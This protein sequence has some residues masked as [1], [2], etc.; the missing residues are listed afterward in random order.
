MSDVN[1]CTADLQSLIRMDPEFRG[2]VQR[3]LAAD[4]NIFVKQLYEDLDD[5]IQN[6]E[7]DKHF[8]QDAKWGE[9]EL[10]A[11]IKNFL[12]GRFYDVEHDT[13]HG[14]HVDLLVKH[15]FGKFEW[16]GETKLWRGPKSIHNGWIQLTERYGTGTSRDDHGGILIY[17]KSDKS[18]VKFNEW[19]EFFSTTVSDAEI[20][21]EGS[22][23]RFK[24]ITK[25]P[26]TALPYHVRHMGVSLYH[27]TGKKTADS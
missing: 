17:I 23:L 7:N 8:Y 10:T 4:K 21:A 3:K 18:A 1:I 24:S 13:Q 2:M 26:A 6:L 14:G 19:K 27:Y 15:Q 5:A 20:E 11:S 25:H 9:D 12:K 16:I 22:P